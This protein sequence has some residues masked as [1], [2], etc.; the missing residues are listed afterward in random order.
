[1]PQGKVKLVKFMYVVVYAEQILNMLR[2]WFVRLIISFLELR[3]Y[4][5]FMRCYC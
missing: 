5:S 3:S 1:M 2:T 4:V